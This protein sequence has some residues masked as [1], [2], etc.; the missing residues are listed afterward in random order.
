MEAVKRIFRYLVGTKDLW[1]VYGG[2][3]KELVGYR[4]VDGSMGEDRKAV[5]GYTFIINGAVS[6]ST[7]HQEIIFTFNDRE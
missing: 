5:S 6:W 1:L 2:Q 7:K 3:S 4:D